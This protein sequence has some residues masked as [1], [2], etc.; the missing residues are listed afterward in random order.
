MTGDPIR[1]AL[2]LEQCWHRVPGG[3]A[4]AAVEL[5]RAIAQR[6]D[7]EVVG[8]A[9]A[10]RGGPVV[11]P[12]DG[13]EIAHLRLPR[14]L[15][16]ESWA[17]L[18]RPR[19]DRRCG[20]PDL[21][22]ATG[23]AVPATRAPLVATVHDL[24]WRHRP[25]HFTTRGRRMFEAW[26][27]AAGRARCVLCPSA[28]TATD[29]ADAG[30]PTERIRVVPLGADLRPAEQADVEALRVRHGLTGNVVLWV[31]VAE[32]RKNLAVLAEAME[33]VPDAVLVMVGA[34]GWGVDIVNLVRPLGERVRIVGPVDDAEKR[35]WYA[36]ADVFAFP[37]LLEGFGLPVLEAMAQ[38]APVVTSAGTST[39]EV[40]GSAG[41]VVQPSDV[42]AWT[43]AIRHLLDDPDEARRLGGSGRSRAAAF[44]WDRTAAGTVDCYR[45]ALAA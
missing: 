6:T 4:V 38:G 15:L 14:P 27:D 3:T 45:E 8:I 7:V 25:D 37:S 18:G 26:L 31:G 21:V 36:L 20:G 30:I 34:P 10:H 43:A 16:Y 29:L 39:E 41:I 9:A 5:A 23:G 2:L 19:V 24:A 11:F 17:R 33:A 42:D 13:I 22:H 35:A 32:P 28:A 1:A 40:V 12:P 44:T